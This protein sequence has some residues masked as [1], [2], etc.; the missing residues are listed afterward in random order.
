MIDTQSVDVAIVGGG[1]AGLTAAIALAQLGVDVAVF[2]RRNTT[3]AL[4]RAHLLNQRTMEVFDAIGVA[5]DVY[6]MSPPE[7]RWHRVAWYTSLAGDRPGQGREIGHIHAWGGGPD[8]ARYAAVSPNRYANVP[9]MRLDPLLRTHADR[10]CPGRIHYGHE[11]TDIRNTDGGVELGVRDND[12]GTIRTIDARYCIGADGG[13]TVSSLLGVAMEGPTQLLDMVSMHVSADLSPWIHDDEVLL[14][15]FVDPAG[16]AGFRGSMCAMGP[17]TWGSQSRE[18]AFH[19]AFAWGTKT[20]MDEESLKDRFRDI[21]G[22]PELEFEVHAV[23]HWEF[24]GVTAERYRVGN[25]FLVGNAAHRHPPTGGLGLNTAVQDVDNLCWKLAQVLRRTAAPGL[26]DTYESERRPIG[27]FNVRHSLENAGAHAK[28]AAALGLGSDTTSAEDGWSAVQ[29]W[30]MPGPAG[31]H[32]R[33]AVAAAVAANGDDYSQLNVEVGFVYEQGAVIPDP[34]EPPSTHGS[35]RDYTPSTRPGHHLPHAWVRR[36]EELVSTL[37]AVSRIDFTLLVDPVHQARWGDAVTSI[38]IPVDVV[39]IGSSESPDWVALRQVG[40]DGAILVRP[41]RHVA[42]RT[43]D[44]PIDTAGELSAALRA[45][46]SR[47]GST[48]EFA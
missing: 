48:H 20:G 46:L 4:P 47:S 30:L 41:D 2:E 23:S 40:P 42:W 6:A 10:H 34:T 25:V 45:L 35:L 39:A 17:D 8:A 28:I 18:W 21:L 19:Q 33:A 5:D 43:A 9:Q 15:Y 24:E 29:S 38:G 3:S 36:G 13:R 7:D 44:M 14:Y 12:T 16:R 26:L 1:P 27:L 32:R 22:L 37:D 31:A 11:V